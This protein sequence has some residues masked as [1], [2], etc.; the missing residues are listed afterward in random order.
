[1]KKRYDK[2][3]IYLIYSIILS[4]WAYGVFLFP[5]YSQDTYAKSLYNYAWSFQE[6]IS[7]G[8][9]TYWLIDSIIYHLF[10]TRA[11]NNIYTNALCIIFFAVSIYYTFS[12][13]LF[14]NKN[15]ITTFLLS[16]VIFINPCFVDYFQFPECNI[17]YSFGLILSITSADMLFN[18]KY[19]YIKRFINSA[20]ILVITVG[21][22]QPIINY[23]LLLGL[24][25]TWKTYINN[26]DTD[27]KT[28]LMK[29]I[30]NITSCIMIY[31]TSS[32]LQ[33]I[34]TS[35]GGSNR[36]IS[37][38]YLQNLITVIKTQVSLWTL[39]T[40]GKKTYIYIILFC[41]TIAFLLILLYK[42]YSVNLGIPLI[43]LFI[44]YSGLYIASF[45]THIIA[46][47]WLSQRTTSIF[48]AHIVLILYA[49]YTISEISYNKI[50]ISISG[51][52]VCIFI[53]RSNDLAIQNIR[54]NAH[55]E[56][57]V[58]AVSQYI[59]SYELENQT[60]INNI[61]IAHDKYVTWS[62]PDISAS[63]DLNVRV[64]CYTWAIS[65]LIHQYT[66]ELYNI[67]PMEASKADKLFG[68]KDWSY[69]NYDQLYAEGDTLYMMI[70]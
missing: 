69:F 49:I 26:F 18:E 54:T 43:V 2:N 61:A 14:E 24:L 52:L 8:R 40:T 51:I 29:L 13:L 42:K 64:W 35:I 7:S 6:G 62:Y 67:I 70:Y 3:W 10:K 60:V 57:I 55:D 59:D 68:D 38:S 46:E 4:F 22:Y 50:I 30:K 56:Q 39:Q 12:I 33:L 5:H 20:L 58:Y 19:S 21:I 36:R 34:L 27:K 65:G 53:Y 66:G 28:A 16:T 1:M 37:K 31:F 25:I 47:P 63:Y 44:L 41:I 48:Y 11:L 17:V 15:K 45:A 32:I 9:Y 23:F